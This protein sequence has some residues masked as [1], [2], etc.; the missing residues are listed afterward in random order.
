MLRREHVSNG[1]VLLVSDLDYSPLDFGA[2]TDILVR[3][4]T[5]RIPLRIVSL[6]A[7]A[8]DREFF[9]RLLGDNV[10]VD[11]KELQ[12]AAG[13]KAK[14]HLSG[15]LPVTLIAFG[16]LCIGLLAINELWCGRLAIPRRGTT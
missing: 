9:K 5:E 16:A 11:Y 8:L 10:V 4:K 1:S 7:S 3:Y 15:M 12:S 14:H 2:L 6:F 13:P